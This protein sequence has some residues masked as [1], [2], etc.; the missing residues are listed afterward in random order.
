MKKSIEQG[1]EKIKPEANISGGE[2][3]MVE[4]IKALNEFQSNTLMKCVHLLF[5]NKQPISV[6]FLKI[7]EFEI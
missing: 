1:L 3:Q 2:I 5:K 4:Y 7:T 6:D